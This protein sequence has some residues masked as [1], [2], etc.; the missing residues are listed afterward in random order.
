MMNFWIETKDKFP[1]DGQRVIMIVDGV[2][3]DGVNYWQ[4][5]HIFMNDCDQE[6]T[7][8]EVS[9]WMPLPEPPNVKE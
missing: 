1:K 8:G 2:V 4:E 6:W 7:E 5:D 3:I 9:H